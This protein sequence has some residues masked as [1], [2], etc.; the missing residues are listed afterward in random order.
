MVTLGSNNFLECISKVTTSPNPINRFKRQMRQSWHWHSQFHFLLQRISRSVKGFVLA[1]DKLEAPHQQIVTNKHLHQAT[2][3][4]TV[5]PHTAFMPLSRLCV[6]REYCT[7]LQSIYLTI[8]C[9]LKCSFVSFDISFSLR[10]TF[11]ICMYWHT[12]TLRLHEFARSGFT[13]KS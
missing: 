4:Q 10:S 7:L 3:T 6:Q 13:E 1:G 8:I 2:K 11:T 5:I 9:H 12:H